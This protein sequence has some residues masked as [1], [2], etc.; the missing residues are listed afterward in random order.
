[1]C[2]II[3]T[4][5][6]II[7]QR[8]A[9]PL[10]PPACLSIFCQVKP[11]IQSNTVKPSE[12]K[13]NQANL[14]KSWEKLFSISFIYIATVQLHVHYYTWSSLDSL[15]FTYFKARTNHRKKFSFFGKLLFMFFLFIAK[16]QRCQKRQIW[17]IYLCYSFQG[18]ANFVTMHW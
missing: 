11:K 4:I 3:T 15:N 17:H 14:V 7:H 9:R 13:K 5:A 12:T 8:F 2:L 18:G 6:G 10:E 1:M 16:N